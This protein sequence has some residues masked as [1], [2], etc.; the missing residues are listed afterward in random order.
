MSVFRRYIA[1][2]FGLK[3]FSL[4]MAVLLWAAITRDQ[5]V[6]DA[7]TVPIDFHAIPENLELKSETIPQ[8]QVRVR[9]PSRVLASLRS[10]AKKPKFRIYAMIILPGDWW[11]RWDGNETAR[12]AGT[13]RRS[14]ARRSLP[15]SRDRACGGE[16]RAC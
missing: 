11:V 7:F 3:V 4:A 12:P 5:T 10:W 16:S 6:E 15:A 14:P 13:M 9:G 2:N 1:Q 8:A